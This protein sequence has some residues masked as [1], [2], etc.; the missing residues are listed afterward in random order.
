MCVLIEE[1]LVVV[2]LVI[3][4][5]LDYLYFIPFKLHH[6]ADFCRLANFGYLQNS[7]SSE[8]HTRAFRAIFKKNLF[9]A[10]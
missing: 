6:D 3:N 7:M 5:Q 9:G 10:S 2:R 1:A 8:S 4:E